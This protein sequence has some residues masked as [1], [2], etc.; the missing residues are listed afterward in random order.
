MRRMDDLNE[1]KSEL[2]AHMR[3]VRRLLDDTCRAGLS[4]AICERLLGL[5]EL[6]GCLGVLAYHAT[7]EEADPAGALSALSALGVRVAMP[8][9]AGPGELG[10]HW[11]DEA[12][13]LA[14]G[15]YGILEPSESAPSVHIGDIDAA[16]VP[17]L[18]FDSS[19]SRLGFGG[20]Y[21]DRLLPLL[22]H[23]TPTIGLAFDEQVVESVPVGPGDAAVAIVVTPTRTLRAAK[24]G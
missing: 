22:P 1:K 6:A 16:I 21:Y 24:A 11:V 18:A 10:L 8:R 17:G 14:P 9:V 12:S 19:G 15:A 20:G 4:T 2:R 23:G 3:D 5:P 13:E 7:A